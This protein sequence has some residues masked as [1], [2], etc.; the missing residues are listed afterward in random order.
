MKKLLKGIGLTFLGLWLIG[1]FLPETTDSNSNPSVTPIEY[2]SGVLS[3]AA[4]SLPTQ[5]PSQSPSSKPSSN[6]Q[7]PATEPTSQVSVSQK[8]AIRR[9]QSYLNFSSFSR[10]GLIEQLEYE[11]FTTEESTFAVDSLAVDWNQQAANK[12]ASY[13]EM[14]G[15]SRSGLI[16]QLM[17]E[18]FTEEQA[19]FG[20]TANG[21]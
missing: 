1:S 8:N 7:S 16:D 5:S 13:L 3:E 15:F 20:A 10:T 2:P 14:T 11:G 18:G 6:T 17:Y 21:L 12:G 9:A 4:K 19:N